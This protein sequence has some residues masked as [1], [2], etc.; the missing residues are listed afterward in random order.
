MIN[1]ELLPKAYTEVLEILKHVPKSDYEKIPKYIIENME[2]EKDISYKYEVCYIDDFSRQEM[3]KETEAIL[4]VFYRDYW[5]TEEQKK[6]IQEI[7]LLERKIAE[8][9]KIKK[10]SL[11]SEAN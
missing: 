2:H 11:T 5:T 6:K 10:Y 4:A 3:L 7:E 1:K 8:E 9:E